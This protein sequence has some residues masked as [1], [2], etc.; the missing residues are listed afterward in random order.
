VSGNNPIGY[1]QSIDNLAYYTRLLS[2]ES[3]QPHMDDNPQW[4]DGGDM[5]DI[6]DRCSELMTNEENADWD[7][8]DDIADTITKTYHIPPDRVMQDVTARML[9]YDI[10]SGMLDE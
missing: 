5:E 9:Q 3:Q 10:D 1:L 2:E 4:M 6:S 7:R 8:L